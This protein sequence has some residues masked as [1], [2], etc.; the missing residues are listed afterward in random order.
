MAAAI[1]LT[2]EPGLV[3]RCWN[4][5]LLQG[6]YCGGG[7]LSSFDSRLMIGVDIDERS[8]EADTLSKRAIKK[9]QQKMATR[10]LALTSRIHGLFHAK[11]P[12]S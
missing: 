6:Y 8:V 1:W 4:S 10:P 11:L 9:R 12:C 3:R 2:V 7:L 5:F